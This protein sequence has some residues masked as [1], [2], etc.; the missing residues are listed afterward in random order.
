MFDMVSFFILPFINF[1]LTFFMFLIFSQAHNSFFGKSDL[2]FLCMLRR[3]SFDIKS[4]ELEIEAAQVLPFE[5]VTS[6]LF[7]F[8]LPFSRITFV[9]NIN[10]RTIDSNMC[11]V[12]DTGTDTITRMIC[13][14]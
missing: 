14:T 10:L 5:N 9:Q 11:C 4:Q 13:K 1:H 2:T 7:C 3:L 6:C 12:Y 8:L